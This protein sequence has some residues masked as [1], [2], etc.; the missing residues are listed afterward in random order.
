MMSKA[1]EVEASSAPIPQANRIA[2]GIQRDVP[3]A[4][5]GL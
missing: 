2:A 5:P 1:D 4:Q 3:D